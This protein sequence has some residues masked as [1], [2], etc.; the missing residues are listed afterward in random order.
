MWNIPKLI[1]DK[2]C[3]ET[4]ETVEYAFLVSQSNNW[5]GMIEMQISINQLPEEVAKELF[6]EE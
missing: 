2:G 1:I 4:N 6:L 3:D 5:P